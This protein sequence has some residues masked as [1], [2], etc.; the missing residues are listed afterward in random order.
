MAMRLILLNNAC[1]A[2]ASR[3]DC[4][5]CV[6]TIASRACIPVFGFFL[7][8]WWSLGFSAYSTLGL[9][10]TGYVIQLQGAWV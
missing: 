1:T 7:L 2:R 8:K 3:M 5:E 6:H 10:F 9:R 4:F